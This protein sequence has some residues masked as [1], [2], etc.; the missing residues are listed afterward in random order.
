MRK[1]RLTLDQQRGEVG[2]GLGSP[3]RDGCNQDRQGACGLDQSDAK[4]DLARSQ[5]WAAGMVLP[6]VLILQFYSDNF[7]IFYIFNCGR[8]YSDF[9]CKPP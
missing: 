6:L 3:R 4:P 5:G 8:Q 2:R 7:G 1:Q 9:H